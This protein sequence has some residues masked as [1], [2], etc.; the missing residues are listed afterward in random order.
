MTRHASS[1]QF[2]LTHDDQ[3]LERA[4]LTIDDIDTVEMNEA[5]AAQAEACR[6]GLHA[7]E[8]REEQICSH[9]TVHRRRHGDCDGVGSRV[10]LPASVRDD[11][12]LGVTMLLRKLSAR[13]HPPARAGLAG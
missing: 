9:L 2:N 10:I 6:Q 1:R 13:P 3:E 11:A 8:V 7:G 12:V 4:G 5:F